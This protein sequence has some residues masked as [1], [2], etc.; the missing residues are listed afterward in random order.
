MVLGFILAHSRRWGRYTA[1]RN[2]CQSLGV[3]GVT[4][5]NAA[6]ET[7]FIVEWMNNTGN[8]IKKLQYN[9]RTGADSRMNSVFKIG[10][11]GAG[12]TINVTRYNQY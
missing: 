9:L 11:T 7:N 1:R 8:T 4:L 10:N 3:Y 2:T 6:G 12:V 5:G